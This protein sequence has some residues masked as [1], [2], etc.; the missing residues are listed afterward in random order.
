MGNWTL[1]L[2]GKGGWD[3]DMVVRFSFRDRD[4]EIQFQGQGNG[5]GC[6]KKKVSLVKSAVA[7]ITLVGGKSI[8]VFL[9]NPD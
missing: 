2:R 5:T 1:S 9:T 4:R 7:N 8:G 6:L 3:R